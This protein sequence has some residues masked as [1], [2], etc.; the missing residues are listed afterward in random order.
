MFVL[1]KAVI[2]IEA[3]TKL[4]LKFRRDIVGKARFPDLPGSLFGHKA[5]LPEYGLLPIEHL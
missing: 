4:E 5:I 2:I 3:S 1:S